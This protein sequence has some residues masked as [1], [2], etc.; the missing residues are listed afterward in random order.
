VPADIV[1]MTR[2]PPDWG[3]PT[4]RQPGGPPAV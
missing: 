2:T 4:R 3:W 1:R